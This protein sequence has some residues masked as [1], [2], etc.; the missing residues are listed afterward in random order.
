MTLPWA[1]HYDPGV[2]LTVGPVTTP[3]PSLLLDAAEHSP[4]ASALAFFGRTLTY[5]DLNT[6]TARLAQALKTLGL[7]KGERVGIFLPNTPQLVI[8]YQ[9]VLR[10]GAV[11]V[12]LNPLL[13]SKELGHQLADSGATRLVLLDHFLPKFE[14][15]R[16]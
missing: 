11:A 8:A 4:Q 13:S 16:D 9:A 5:G 10:L 1:R 2:P 7:A 3:L 6:L 14:E 12:M 15:I